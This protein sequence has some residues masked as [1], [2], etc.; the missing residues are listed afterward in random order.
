M[1]EKRRLI[2]WSIAGI[3]TV[4]IMGSL[5]HYGYD[6]SGRNGVI[7]A[8]MPVNESVW[9]H[10]KLLFFPYIVFV[11]TEYIV[12]GRKA[13]GF[14]FSRTVGLLCGMILIPVLFY[15]YTGMIGMNYFIADILTFLTAVIMSFYISTKR[16][17]TGADQE[18]KTAPAVI[19][20]VCIGMLFVGFTFFP[21]EAPLFRA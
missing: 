21:P 8:I 7:G 19:L 6:L 1:L 16:I 13:E 5:F 3:I 18:S 10:L 11:I 20:L 14:L 15:S 17:V 12:Y 4:S 9:E 2:M